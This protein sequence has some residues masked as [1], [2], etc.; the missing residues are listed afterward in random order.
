MSKSEAATT[1]AAV[2]RGRGRLGA[3]V[4]AGGSA[5]R[6]GGAA[7]PLCR[8]GG[9]TLLGRV[10]AAVAAADPRVVVGPG[11]LVTALPNGVSLT[12]EANP[13]SGPVAAVAEGVSL[14]PDAVD[15]VAVLSADMP[16]LPAGV[17]DDLW[18]TAVREA[19]DGAVVVDPNHGPQWLCGVWSRDRLRA[20]IEAIADPTN[21]SLR[22]FFG[23]L[24]FVA[25]LPAD[26]GPGGV[27]VWFDC[28]SDD[29]LRHAE[30]ALRGHISAQP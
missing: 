10:L 11:D 20:R 24:A 16:F 28:D 25:Y 6:M 14:L 18:Q 5:R 9:V 19:A 23:D 26:S 8:V 13:G 27:P 7:K 12:R 1:A 30:D 3:L 17:I 21:R 29:D 2:R 22:E 4:L 15:W